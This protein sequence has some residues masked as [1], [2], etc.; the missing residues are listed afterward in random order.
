MGDGW[1]RAV[2]ATRRTRTTL[3]GFCR[4]G[5]YRWDDGHESDCPYCHG[6]GLAPQ[7]S[8]DSRPSDG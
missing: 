7:S 1:K 6:S 5:T 8:T 4:K 3:C 2:E